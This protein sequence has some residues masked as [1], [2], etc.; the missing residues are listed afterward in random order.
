[1]SK[2]MSRRTFLE[3]SGLALTASVPGEFSATA[4]AAERRLFAY[5]GR[6]CAIAG[7]GPMGD[8]AGLGSTEGGGI[9]VFRVNMADGSLELVSSTGP[10]VADLNSDGICASADGRFVYCVNRT[11]ALGWV[12]GT[13]G[14]VSAFAINR[15]D[16]SLRHLNTRPSMGSM[17]ASVRIDRTNSRVIVG[18]HGAT[19]RVA[20]VRKRNGVPVIE[21]PTDSATVALFPVNADGSLESASDAGVFA[22]QP[23]PGAE[24]LPSRSLSSPLGPEAGFQIGAACHA[25]VFDR[26]ER[27]VIASDNGY[28]HLYVYGFNPTS[29]QL[30]VGKSYPLPP[31]R[32]PR[33]IVVHPRAPYFFI[34]NESQPSVSVFHFD[35]RAGV[36]RLIQT[37]ATVP[38]G[39]T[40]APPA[41]A[42]GSDLPAGSG[43]AVSPS[44]IRIHPNGKF[45]YSS[46]RSL[47]GKDTIAIFA[48]DEGTGRLTMV[49][50]VETGGRGQ[51]EFDFEPSG[52]YLFSCNSDSDD[53][54]SY[55][56]DPVTGKLT[57]TARIAVQ[58]V[59][60]ITFAML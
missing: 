24:N 5:V 59:S 19:A 15:E 13:G 26:T 10:E 12:P 7:S 36:P 58:R 52:R 35:S 14:G 34:T 29:R 53:V 43:K 11:P 47:Q 46:N 2:G 28:D 38:G 23:A 56:V 49:D 40:S 50:L 21:R 51:R 42:P 16:G 27:W 39:D 22:D 45:V 37:I 20:L 48:V 41:T 54:I 3:A 31:G 57:R 8:V 4:D 32:S 44:D 25:A 17:P 60:V 33:H 6:Q 9:D 30:G 55:S 18:N 1:M